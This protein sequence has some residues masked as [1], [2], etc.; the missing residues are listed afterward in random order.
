MLEQKLRFFCV[1]FLGKL[2]TQKILLLTFP[3]LFKAKHTGAPVKP[4]KVVCPECDQ[5]NLLMGVDNCSGVV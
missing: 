3:D 2:M 1:C 5:G 4:V